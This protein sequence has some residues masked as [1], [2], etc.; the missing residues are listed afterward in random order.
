MIR[1]R[2]RMSWLAAHR[3]RDHLGERAASCHSRT[4]PVVNGGDTPGAQE[5]RNER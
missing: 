3:R 4:P 2:L 1:A 5:E